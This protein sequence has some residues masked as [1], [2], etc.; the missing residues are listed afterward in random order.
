MSRVEKERGG[1]GGVPPYEAVSKPTRF[2]QPRQHRKMRV[3]PLL[4]RGQEDHSEQVGLAGRLTPKPEP[5][6]GHFI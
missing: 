6:T 4:T 1:V 2:V 3:W 5:I